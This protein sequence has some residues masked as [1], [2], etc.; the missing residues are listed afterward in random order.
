MR[1]FNDD[2]SHNSNS[3]NSGGSIRCVESPPKQYNKSRCV[4]RS[5]VYFTSS[6]THESTNL[7]NGFMGQYA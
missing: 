1:S 4:G 6:G 3:S 2:A 7:T 5:Y